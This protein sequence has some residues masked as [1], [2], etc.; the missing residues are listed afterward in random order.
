MKKEHK[1]KSQDISSREKAAALPVRLE[2]VLD[3]VG[4]AISIQD[5]DFRVLYQ[6]RTHKALTGDHV[7]E[8]C[9]R[10]YNRRKDVCPGCPVAMTF[11]DGSVHTIRKQ[12]ESDLGNRY[13]EIIS[14]SLKDSAGNIIA[15]IESVRDI[16]ERK[17]T[18]EALVSSEQKYLALLNNIQDGVYLVRDFRFQ[19]VNENLARMIGYTAGEMIGNEVSH[20]IAPEDVAM[21]SGYYARRTSGESAPEEYE[22]HLLHKDGHTRITVIIHAG[23]VTL[24]DGVIA[25]G[26]I[27][28]VTERK[29]LEDE[30]LENQK[31]EILGNLAGGI[32]HEYNNILTAIAGNISLAKMYAKPGLEVHD[33]LTEAEKASLRAKHL[34]QQLLTFSK[35]GSPVK[36]VFPFS[37]ILR[38]SASFILSG[39]AIKCEFSL[40]DDPLPVDGDENQ[41]SQAVNNIIINAKESMPQGGSILITAEVIEL[42]TEKPFHFRTGKYIKLSLKDQGIGIPKEFLPRV[43]EPFF[44]TKKDHEGLGLTTTY[45]VIKKHNGY[46]SIQSQPGAGTTIIIYLPIARADISQEETGA[47]AYP[48]GRGRVLVMEDEGLVQTVIARMLDQ[49]G[50]D[51]DFAKNGE[52]TLEFYARAIE[53]GKYYDAVIMDLIIPGG[54]GGRETIGKL[55]ELDPEVK[56]VVSSGYSSDP[57]MANYREYGFKYVLPK[58]YKMEELCTILSKAKSALPD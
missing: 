28:N 55:L 38:N 26:T 34:T 47:M 24:E 10:A 29:K 53:S 46:I 37:E 27:K 49:C 22:C 54:M 48:T 6:N 7:G 52:E 51:A 5:R 11:E 32:A 14:S 33:I 8:F 57:I 44:T 23:A 41:I 30:L 39:S 3:D 35:G 17:K 58:P 4:D 31:L 45:S 2:S 13:V 36:K 40:P 20:F 15:G 18:E 42:D 19:Y 21:V 12:G 25:L 56:A 50:F 43:F 16:T 1:K 9:Y